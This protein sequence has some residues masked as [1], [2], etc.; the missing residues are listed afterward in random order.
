MAA[1]STALSQA[2]LHTGISNTCIR[3][4][5]P[6]LM[7]PVLAGTRTQVLPTVAVPPTVST[8]S[9]M[10][11]LPVATVPPIG[12]TV[13]TYETALVGTT[14]PSS[15]TVIITSAQPITSVKTNATIH[16]PVFLTNQALGKHSLQTS[17]L[18]FHTNVAS[19]LLISPDGAVLSTAQCQVNPTELTACPKPLDALL[20]SPNSSRGALLTHDSSFLPPQA[21]TK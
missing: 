20:V 17:A 5:V 14:P 6:A 10:Q 11:T 9:R 7:Q 13:N 18:G 8:V 12:S 4:Q 15:S 16:P 1:P 19:K 3:K 21:D 2:L